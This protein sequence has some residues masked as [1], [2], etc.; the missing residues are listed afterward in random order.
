MTMTETPSAPPKPKRKY[1]VRRKATKPVEKA[2]PP[3]FAGLSPTDCCNAC[4]AS[5]CVISGI[6]ICSHPMK[7]GLQSALMIRDDVMRR[8]NRAKVFLAKAKIDLTAG[9]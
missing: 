4:T 9:T 2:P 8:Y 7:G 3:E 5:K 6:G 1:V